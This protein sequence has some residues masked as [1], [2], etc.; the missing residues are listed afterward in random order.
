MRDNG[1][2]DDDTRVVSRVV[3]AATLGISDRISK[4]VVRPVTLRIPE[5]ALRGLLCGRCQELE[6][7]G[8]RCKQ[9]ILDGDGFTPTLTHTLAGMD[10]R[11]WL[12]TLYSYYDRYPNSYTIH[13]PLDVHKP[14]HPGLGND[15]YRR[16][17]CY[18]GGEAISKWQE[19]PDNINVLFIHSSQPI[20]HDDY[21]LFDSNADP[22]TLHITILA[23][24]ERSS[25]PKYLHQRVIYVIIRRIK[26]I[27]CSNLS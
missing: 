6:A 20:Y 26:C 18:H 14:V 1:K 23:L 2:D 3:M 12:P 16:S 5:R 25:Y 17:P 13:L 7:A 15:Y 9:N 4:S 24:Y 10:L 19:E 21:K 27:L 8:R 22:S 11:C